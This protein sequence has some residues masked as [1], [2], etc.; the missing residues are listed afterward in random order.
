ML[1][2]LLVLSMLYIVWKSS[3]VGFGMLIE[4]RE[5]LIGDREAFDGHC[6]IVKCVSKIKDNCN[7]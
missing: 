5:T 1:L 2:M 7:N 4:E 6:L 3:R